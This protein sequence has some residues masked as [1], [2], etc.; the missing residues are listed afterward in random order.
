MATRARWTA[1]HQ[2]VKLRDDIRSD[3]LAMN[4]FAAD[5]YDVV[6][7]KAKP[8]YQKPEEFFALTYPTFNLRELA[9]D[10]LVRL[11]GKNDK[12]VR[13]LELTYGGGKTHA[14]ITLYHLVHD[15]ANLPDL[16]AVH[17]FRQHA[18]EMVP[19]KAR[20][21]VL[22]FDKF[23]VEKGMDAISPT[24][25]MR[26][27]RQPWSVIAYQI[28]GDEGLKLL[29]AENKAEERETPPAEN[30]LQELL[31]LPAKENLSTLILIDE[32]LTYA[33]EKVALD[34]RYRDRLVDFFQ[35][36]TQAVTKVDKTCMVASLLATDPRK[37]DDLGKEIARDLHNIFLRQQ[38]Q[39]VL[40]VEK[41][42][43]AEVL[44]R[45]FFTPTSIHDRESF[46]QHVVAAIEGI[47]ALDEQTQKNR[48]VEEDRYL[49][50]YPF[51]PDLTEA[52]YSK[53]TQL[54]NFQRTRGVLRT[55]AMA[56]KDAEKWDT[57]PLVSTNAFLTA[58]GKLEI[59]AAARELASIARSEEYEGRAQDWSRILQSELE[60]ACAIEKDYPAL[61]NRELEQAVMGTF[62]HSQPVGQR[63]QTRELMVL[64]GATRPD[65]IE[66]EKS[67]REWAEKSWWLDEAALSDVAGQLPKTWRLG[68]RPNLRQMLSQAV[69]SVDP[70]L[71]DSEMVDFIRKEKRLSVGAGVRTHTL[72][73]S[74]ADIEDD[75]D[76]HYVILG[77][78]A[79]SESGKP[80][81]E[82]TR[83]I[84]EK[85]S[86]E[87][88]R[89]YQNA[90]LA[91]TPSK[92]GLSLLRGRVQEYLGWQ[93]V[94][95]LP[96]AKSFDDTLR[97][98]LQAKIK[99]AKDKIP[100]AVLQAYTIVVDVSD[101]G[102]V[103]AFKITP[104]DKPLFETIKADKRS[105]IQD[106]A[107][108]PDALLPEGPYNLWQKG[109]TSRRASDLITAFAQFSHLP[110]MLKK[111]SIIDTI[112]LGTEQGY[113][114]L[115]LTRPDKSIKTIWRTRPDDTSLQERDLEVVLPE[116]LELTSIDSNLLAP[117]KL[118]GLWPENKAPVSVA[119][120]VQFFDGKHV[121]KVKHQGYEETFSV[122]KA[123]K[124][125]VENAVSEAVKTGLIWLVSPPASIFKEEIPLGVMSDT[126]TLNPP[127]DDIPTTKLLKQNLPGAWGNQTYTTAAAISQALS[128]EAGKPLPWV[129]IS[130]VL[131]G[132]IQSHF[133]E[134][135]TDTRPWPC[136]WSGAQ[137]AHFRMPDVA[138]LPP[139]EER[140]FVAMAELEPAEL[141]DFVDSMPEII[142]AGVGL[143][144]H[145]T[146]RLELGRDV[147]PSEEQIKKLNEILKK[148]SDKLG[149]K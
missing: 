49:Q 130:R 97:L 128:A 120:T 33:R 24:G 99:V 47:Q 144:L 51:H 125:V 110:K 3:D 133:L 60:K 26:L 88:K 53:W 18:G 121:S 147:K 131:S 15:P 80:S 40:P 119:D 116:A 14:L 126:A 64:V 36:L 19:P 132:A 71:I 105:R 2:V 117:G 84:R 90:I 92:D 11:S 129:I 35:Y 76:F 21:A 68:T 100:D 124:T 98:S 23:D 58:P 31:S 106:A 79:A 95:E 91:V 89:T 5:L 118:P 43:V 112:A 30:L 9:K 136:D 104:E 78:T 85:T 115:R 70:D 1:W 134:K 93:R 114:A 50:S 10:V 57:A 32:V 146:L 82:A 22:P 149:L 42:D 145:Y 74:P 140:G 67:L 83:Y 6:M 101:K 103:E 38:E 27:L 108:S 17:E 39:A 54:Q 75:G 96:D 109:E 4:T 37:S 81:S 59:S 66:L 143:D 87:N 135:T 56:L 113:L 72:P 77:P 46:R 61:R 139:P 86:P 28:A 45:R 73:K 111:S 107:V 137:A 29:H 141:Q 16:P 148:T 122:P 52:F 55:F 138:P 8:I 7:G 12:A 63:A 69:L 41:Q 13:Q 48:K 44:R 20:I 127:P 25:T 123:S 62:L 142:K 65:K 94:A 102:A 34:A